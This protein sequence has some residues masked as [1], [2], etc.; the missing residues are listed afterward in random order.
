MSLL[1]PISQKD[2]RCWKHTE[3]GIQC[4]LDSLA[5]S[6]L[7]SGCQFDFALSTLSSPKQWPL[8]G[9]DAHPYRITAEDEREEADGQAWV[10]EAVSPRVAGR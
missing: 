7:L 9:L 8:V 3:L 6:L 5:A 2:K 4:S 10:T 1:V